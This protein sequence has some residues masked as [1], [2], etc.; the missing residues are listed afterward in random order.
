MTKGNISTNIS[1][2]VKN[3]LNN[4]GVIKSLNLYTTVV[5]VDEIRLIKGMT[6]H[7]TE[8][9]VFLKYNIVMA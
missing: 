4:E 7:I 9:T 2:N 5:R 8:T 6:N 3:K 1:T